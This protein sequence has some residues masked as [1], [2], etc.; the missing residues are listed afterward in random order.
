MKK[1]I[2][3]ACLVGLPLVGM[4]NITI[5]AYAQNDGIAYL[6]TSD[7]TT[8]GNTVFSGGQ[9]VIDTSGLTG[10]KE[11]GLAISYMS[12]QNW[13]S[14]IAW[15]N[16]NN[17]YQYKTLGSSSVYTI[18]DA[19][20]GAVTSRSLGN[21]SASVTLSANGPVGAYDNDTNELDAQLGVY[22]SVASEDE[23]VNGTTI[24]RTWNGDYLGSDW[25]WTVDDAGYLG[26]SLITLT[27]NAGTFN[28]EFVGE[29]LTGGL[30]DLHFLSLDSGTAFDAGSIASNGNDVVFTVNGLNPGAYEDG[31]PYY[32]LMDKAWI[33]DE[34]D[35]YSEA[36]DTGLSLSNPDHYVIPEPSVMALFL[37]A[38]SSLLVVRRF[39]MM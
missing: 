21:T 27:N 31:T 7:G 36:Y 29:D 4:A 13:Y 25:G 28:A 12:G 33:Y 26:F 24:T 20:T 39:A 22:R 9:A 17:P 35:N 14:Q 23:A 30:Y 11:Y 3:A 16:G 2:I 15:G 32:V 19:V 8:Y 18:K 1:I 5:N 37:V 10:A 6:Y 34:D 38:G